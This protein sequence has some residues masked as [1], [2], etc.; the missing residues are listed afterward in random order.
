[1]LQRIFEVYQVCSGVSTC[2]GWYTD[3]LSQLYLSHK[4]IHRFGQA[5]GILNILQM[6]NKPETLHHFGEPAV[7]QAVI[8]PYHGAL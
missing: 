4:M 3:H 1:M 2:T 7:G 8:E 6:I 5:K